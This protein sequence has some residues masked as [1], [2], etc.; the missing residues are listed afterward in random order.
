MFLGRNMIASLIDLNFIEN[1]RRITRE[2]VWKES[3]KELLV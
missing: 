3:I 2:L 1:M